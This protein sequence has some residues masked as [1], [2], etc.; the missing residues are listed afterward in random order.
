QA[1][2]ST[3]GIHFSVQPAITKQSYLRVFQHDDYF[4]GLTRLGQLARSKDPLATFELGPNP[5]RDTAYAN[6]VRHVALVVRGSRLHVFFTG[7]RDAPERV[8]M[9]TIDLASDWTTWRAS[10]PVDVLQ[11]ETRYECAEMPAAPSEPGDIE[12]K[13]RQIRDPF[14]FEDQ[15]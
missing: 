4:Y 8:L 2:V 3:D 14:V 1:A 9:S 6:R 11:P 5:F 15:G 10:P 7:I 12:V 13:V